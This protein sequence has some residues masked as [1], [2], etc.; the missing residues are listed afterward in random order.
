VQKQLHRRPLTVRGL[1]LK[2]LQQQHLTAQEQLGRSMQ[3]EKDLR[4]QAAE[5][6]DTVRQVF[7]LRRENHELRDA[8]QEFRLQVERH[9]RVGEELER[10]RSELSTLQEAHSKGKVA[11]DQAIEAAREE[12][13][14]MKQAAQDARSAA[15]RAV[16]VELDAARER[17][18]QSEEENQR[19]EEALQEAHRILTATDRSAREMASE[20]DTLRHDA[21][22]RVSLPPTA[23]MSR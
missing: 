22:C 4:S 10:T 6:S 13:A 5:A 16:A 23:Q 2:T 19:L 1:Q 21:V 7:Q 14:M 18:Q 17:L 8:L 9:K 12:T 20:L 15:E 11:R 3:R